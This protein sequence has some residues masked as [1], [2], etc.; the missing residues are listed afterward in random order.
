[1]NNIEFY[2]PDDI[3][4]EVSI[5]DAEVNQLGVGKAGKIGSLQLVL[6]KDLEGKRT[7]IKHQQSK[8]PLH[9]QRALYYEKELPAMAHLYIISPSG[10]ILQGDRYRIDITLKNNA[11]AHMTT[12]GAT[13]LYRMNANSATQLI[14]ITVDKDCYMEFIPD[15]IIPFCDSR[16]YQKLNM[17]VHD[18]ATMVYS[19]IIVSGRVAMGESFQYDICYMRTVAKNQDDKF[20]FVDAMKL[21]PKK[22]NMNVLGVLGKNTVVGTIYILTKKEHVAECANRIN[23]S[24]QHFERISGGASI[25]PHESGV[26]VRLLGNQASDVKDFVYETVKIVRKKVL[27]APFTGMRKN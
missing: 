24:L 21:E 3:P 20:R 1:M 27:N 12:Q 7:I 10:G 4:L 17:K 9:V 11:I 14:N 26:I 2:I 5:Y 15:Q 8:V 13:R 25:L 23:S 19:E 18:T 22:Q 16:F 6:E